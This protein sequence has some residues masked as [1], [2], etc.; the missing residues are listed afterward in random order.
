LNVR[1]GAIGSNER[2]SMT[3][4]QMKVAGW[5]AGSAGMVAASGFP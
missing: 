1:C 4:A 2:G 5:L 3:S